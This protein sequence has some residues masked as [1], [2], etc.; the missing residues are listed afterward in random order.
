MW[1][2]PISEMLNQ[3][4]G[5]SISMITLRNTLKKERERIRIRI[6]SY[7]FSKNH[8]YH[9]LDRQI[10]KPDIGVKATC[11]W[12]MGPREHWNRRRWKKNCQV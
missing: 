2:P 11:V 12:N 10:I 3:L 9:T 6:K 1:T 4:S 7:I 5:L 8:T